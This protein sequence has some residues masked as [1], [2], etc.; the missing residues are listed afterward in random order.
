[1][2]WSGGAVLCEFLIDNNAT[3]GRTRLGLTWFVGCSHEF[4]KKTPS[5][6]SFLFKTKLVV[7]SALGQLNKEWM[8]QIIHMSVE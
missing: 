8:G 7:P 2:V 6:V 3:L 4:D 5:H 1:M